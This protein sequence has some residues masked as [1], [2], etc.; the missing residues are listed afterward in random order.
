[1]S[2]GPAAPG[3]SLVSFNAKILEEAHRAPNPVR[4]GVGQGGRFVMV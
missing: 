3:R 4:A 2:L 1:M